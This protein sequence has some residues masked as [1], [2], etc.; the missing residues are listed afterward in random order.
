MENNTF[1]TS[2]NMMIKSLNRVAEEYP[3]C[4]TETHYE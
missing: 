4:G 2:I 1:L 3:Y